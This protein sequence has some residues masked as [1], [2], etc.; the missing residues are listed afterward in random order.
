MG[1]F[2]NGSVLVGVPV[3]RHPVNLAQK[4]LDDHRRDVSTT[5]G[6]IIDDESL[7][8]ELR[9]VPACELVKSL[10]SHVRDIDVAY[11]AAGFLLD[12]AD[13]PHHPLVVFERIFIGDRLDH[14]LA[15]SLGG[16]LADGQFDKFV[17]FSDKEPVDVVNVLKRLSVNGCDEIALGDIHSRFGQR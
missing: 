1:P 7:L 12:G 9:I 3:H 5:V 14:D 6:T 8:V 10:R 4:P 16:R 17:S 2:R 15:S 11:L 13:V